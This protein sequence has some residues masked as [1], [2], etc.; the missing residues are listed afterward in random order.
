[1]LHQEEWMD[2][3]L[4][5]RQGQS[6][7]AI[8]RETGYSRNTVRRM[9]RLTAAPQA[10]QRLRVS[11][12]DP[13]KEYLEERYAQC[14]LSA[15]RLWEEIRAQGYAGSEV[16][17][18]RYVQT[19]KPDK[20]VRSR[21]TVR[22]ETPPGEQAQADWAY[23][24]KFMDSGGQSVS[25]YAFVMVLGYSRLRYV[26]FTTSMRM[27]HLLRCLM[28]AFVFFQGV[29]KVVLFDNMK[30]VRLNASTWNPL[31]LDFA[32]HYGFMPKTHAPYRPRSKG[33]VERLVRFVKDN[34]LNG[35]NF[36]DRDDLNA[37]CRVW[38]DHVNGK[39]H[40]TTGRIP[41]EVWQKEERSCLFSLNAVAPYQLCRQATR[42]VDWEGMVRFE[43]SRY[44]VPPRHAGQRVTVEL[45]GQH[46]TVRCGDV[47]IASHAAASRADSHVVQPEHLEALWK[48]TLKRM[49]KQ[50][51]PLPRWQMSFG[52]EVESADLKQYQQ[53][54]E[55]TWGKST[56][57]EGA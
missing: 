42:I 20:V 51:V 3:Q 25:I 53:W 35:K 30:Q 46:I 9:L 38:L 26:E 8:S 24:G 4:L 37:Q 39:V 50:P 47:I 36:T 15:V 16:T 14:G 31:M 18:R 45:R 27:E 10:S 11:N 34:F 21:L 1:M 32:G 2:V 23:C 17:V 33:K 57:K 22:F 48:T 56:F 40:G 28:N 19:L 55:N 52:H 41:L 12:L 43:R 7:R 49:E 54:A 6:I 29:P 5:Y 13:Y 44:S